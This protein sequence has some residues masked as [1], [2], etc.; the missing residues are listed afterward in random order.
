MCCGQW[1]EIVEMVN[2]SEP[3][4]IQK[5]IAIY[6]ILD[7]CDSRGRKKET[8]LKCNIGPSNIGPGKMAF[9]LWLIFGLESNWRIAGEELRRKKKL[10]NHRHHKSWAH[11]SAIP[12][13]YFGKTLNWHRTNI[14]VSLFEYLITWLLNKLWCSHQHSCCVAENTPISFLII[15]NHQ[16]ALEGSSTDCEI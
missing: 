16:N 7:N 2:E 8:P 6:N 15:P 3:S 4:K 14:C 5:W 12:A 9:H 13:V 11:N 10:L 1:W